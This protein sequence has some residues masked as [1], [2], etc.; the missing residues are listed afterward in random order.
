MMLILTNNIAAVISGPPPLTSQL[1]LLLLLEKRQTAK[2]PKQQVTITT[3][4]MHYKLIQ[5][6][7]LFN[8]IS[9]SAVVNAILGWSVGRNQTCSSWWEETR[10][11]VVGG[12]I[13]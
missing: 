5:I 10:H 4:I 1:L 8:T 7:K 9:D 13:R 12:M 11:V 3:Y 2:L 6:V